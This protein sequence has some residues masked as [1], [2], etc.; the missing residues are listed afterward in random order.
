VSRS[1]GHR[2]PPHNL[3]AEEAV[4]GAA[5]LS[6][7]ARAIAVGRLTPER[8]YMSAHGHIFATLADLHHAG[9]PVDA[10]TVADALDRRGL[11]GDIGGR[12][13]LIDLQAGT[14][15]T[16]N[17]GRYVD[18]IERDADARR[19]L[20][21]AGELSEAIYGGAP[22]GPVIARLAE[23]AAQLRSDGGTL[24]EPVDW[25]EFWAGDETGPQWLVEPV[26]PAG[27]SV[28]VYAEPKSGKSLLIGELAVAVATGRPALDRGEAEPA[29]VVYLDLEMSEDDVRER[30]GDMG[31][32]AGDDLSRLHYYLLP[33]LPPLDTAAGG[34]ALV[35]IAR[36]HEATLVVIDTMGRAVAGEED[37]ADTFRGYWRHTGRAL[38]AE[39]LTVVRLDHAGKDVSRGQRGSSSKGDDVDV[40]WR[41]ARADGNGV[42]LHREASRIPWVPERVSLVRHDEP[43]LRHVVSPYA[44]PAGTAEVA[45]LL[46]SLDVDAGASIAVA[47]AALRAAGHAKRRDVVAA[48]LR[49]RRQTQAD[50]T[51]CERGTPGGTSGM[52]TGVGT[53]GNRADV[54]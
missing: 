53:G 17:A 18:I 50:G 44:W 6:A 14:P 23:Q 54:P 28:A 35:A 5:L 39:G 7:E 25:C 13:K 46:D 26:L 45:H 20:A 9:V 38:K 33:S 21:Y 37:R 3:A 11:L 29:N 16:T 47:A 40:V 8:F 41:L 12:L 36:K 1:N 10:V 30:L 31:Y 2:V 15:S 24:P 27:R 48:A 22:L 32:G 4:L 51:T 52:S 43:A 42:V 19:W 49:Y 34:D